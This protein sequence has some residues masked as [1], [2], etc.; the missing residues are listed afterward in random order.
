M[1]ASLD[2]RAFHVRFLGGS[3]DDAGVGQQQRRR[4]R[5]AHFDFAP[6][7]SDM[8]EVPF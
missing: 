6:P 5:S 4:R 1:G 3:Q 2:L 8:G 7:T